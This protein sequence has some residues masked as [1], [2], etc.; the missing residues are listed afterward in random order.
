MLIIFT[1]YFIKVMVIVSFLVRAKLIASTLHSGI[2]LIIF[3][4]YFIKVKVAV[5]IFIKE[6]FIADM[7]INLLMRNLTFSIDIVIK[8]TTITIEGR[9]IF[10]Q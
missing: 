7:M 5:Y 3:T 10:I 8:R 1:K 9:I 6:H 4:K 2:M